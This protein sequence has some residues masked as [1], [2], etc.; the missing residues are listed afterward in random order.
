M[1]VLKQYYS[2]VCLT[3]VCVCEPACGP[4]RAVWRADLAHILGV[5][6]CLAPTAR[7]RSVDPTLFYGQG[8]TASGRHLLS[9]SQC[10][11]EGQNSH[12]TAALC[13]NPPGEDGEQ[14]ISDMFRVKLQSL[15]SCSS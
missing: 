11:G 3:C 8:A 6:K 4:V 5:D 1:Q 15:C 10:R 2:V 14:V 9:N 12:Q 13:P 7:H